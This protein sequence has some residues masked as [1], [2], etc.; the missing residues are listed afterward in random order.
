[1]T[2]RFRVLLPITLAALI[3][4]CATTSSDQAGE[5]STSLSETAQSIDDMLL[6]LDQVTAAISELVN[7][8]GAELDPHFDTFS[9]ALERLTSGAEVM[10]A[11]ATAMREQ[12]SQGGRVQAVQAGH[13]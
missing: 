1:M 6:P 10:K 8:S 11:R 7:H 5:T 9:G 13:G 12:G 4:S 2:M 3:A